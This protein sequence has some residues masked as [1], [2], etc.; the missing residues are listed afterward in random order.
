MFKIKLPKTHGTKAPKLKQQR[1]IILHT[2][3]VD[4][5]LLELKLQEIYGKGNYS[6]DVSVLSTLSCAMLTI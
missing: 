1:G 4:I 5:W 3:K 2:S 6:I